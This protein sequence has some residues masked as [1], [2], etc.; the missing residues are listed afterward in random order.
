MNITKQFT[1]FMALASVS[2]MCFSPAAQAAIA[3]KVQFVHGNVKVT[4]AGVTR[5]LKKGD[6]IS[7]GD[8]ISTALASSAQVK[9]QDG[10]FVAIRP[11]T[12]MKFDQFVFNGKQDGSE[13]SFFTLLKG[14]FRAV[15]GL[16]GTKNKRN[17][18]IKTPSATIG[19]RGTD[20]ESFVV[21]VGDAAVLAGTYS[22]VNVGET[23]LTTNRGTINVLPN[24]M[25]FS[26]GLNAL[27]IL[28]PINTNIF[29]VAAAPTKTVKEKA[30]EKTAKAEQAGSGQKQNSQNG[31][32]GK[33]ENG[34]AQGQQ[35]GDAK[36]PRP[37]AA[38]PA[39]IRSVAADSAPM[40]HQP[41]P[42]GAPLPGQ[43]IGAPHLLVPIVLV[44]ATT[45]ATLNSTTQTLIQGGTNT[46]L[47]SLV[48]A[49]VTNP[50]VVTSLLIADSTGFM[51]F[52][53]TYNFE[54]L[55]SAFSLG[56]TDPSFSVEWGKCS[57]SPC[58]T[59]ATYTMTGATGAVTGTA[60][61]V[62]STGIKFGRYTMVPT[63]TTTW[64][65]TGAPSSTYSQTFSSGYSNWITGPSVN[66]F[67]LP[68][69][70]VG[71]ATYVLD[72]GTAPVTQTGATGV[73]G[74]A[75]L[76]V[77]FT[78]QSVGVDL[79]VSGGGHSWTATATALPL[80]FN[81]GVGNSRSH[82]NSYSGGTTSIYMDS[83]TV[84]QGYIA[85]Q[86]TGNGINGA[87][88]QYYFTDSLSQSISGV[89]AFRLD[90]FNGAPATTVN[91]AT[92]YQLVAISRY[93]ALG[94]SGSGSNFD[95]NGAFNNAGRVIKDA[96]GNLT[97]FD[98]ATNMGSST[99]AGTAGSG[100]SNIFSIGTATATDQGKDPVSG[101][102]WGRWQGGSLGVTDRV[103]NTALAS[104]SNA[105]SS[106][107]WLT[108]P[109]MNGPV[110]LP[111]SGTYTYTL[112]GGTRP[113]DNLGNAG[114]LNGATLQ[115]NFSAMTVNVGVSATVGA[116]N[117]VATGTN[118]PIRQTVFGDGNGGGTFTAT[119]NGVAIQGGL[120]GAFTGLGATGAGVV[121]GFQNSATTINGVLAFHR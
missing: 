38:G 52:P 47:S 50:Y 10:G 91:L 118:L 12:Q 30:E 83:V 37:G 108:T 61:S 119:A 65:L 59:G 3:G 51:Y 4:T 79:A 64:L 39:P 68:E 97:R 44:N 2:L 85:G 88:L 86:L 75:S 17:Y 107:H 40:G 21:P 32:A 15:T 7:E 26:S 90:S 113:T 115:A 60:N 92:P 106:L 69:A 87:F 48:T 73:L 114:T 55:P 120:G 33:Q 18:R 27:P 31:E 103:T 6:R 93:D 102:S 110:T 98:M 78:N 77:N 5:V 89:T 53:Y 58:V 8:F 96:A 25:G 57:V 116:T 100:N 121:Y 29:T 20:H 16:I 22:K 72:G 67:Y 11:N 34:D 104:V 117:Y 81:S 46:A 54:T 82:F 56:A 45:G 71:T 49:P 99:Q 43:V 63:L 101:I 14:G 13:R 74:S 111:A 19:I 41:P 95:L 80:G 70:M 9:M 76:S 24:Q 94:I 112:G 105:T 35:N 84:G 1:S 62:S 36:E 42:G 109:V 23:S 28:A 66:P